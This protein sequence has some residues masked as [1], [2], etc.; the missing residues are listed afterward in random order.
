MLILKMMEKIN[1]SRL[2]N[3]RK[4]ISIFILICGLTN[5]IFINPR[6]SHFGTKRFNG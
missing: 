2:L 5:F 1:H 6:N 3:H 4:I